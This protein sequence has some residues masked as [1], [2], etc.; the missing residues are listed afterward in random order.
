MHFRGC[1][2][3]VTAPRLR[4]LTCGRLDLEDVE[5]AGRPQMVRYGGRSGPS[6]YSMGACLCELAA[7]GGRPSRPAAPDQL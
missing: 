4:C 5:T 1:E 6:M 3:S 7:M 2:L